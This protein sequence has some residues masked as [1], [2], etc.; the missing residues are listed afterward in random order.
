MPA[1]PDQLDVLV[2]PS[3]WPETRCLVIAEAMARGLPVLASDIGAIKDLV[4]DG[5]TG[6]LFPPN[7]PRALSDRIDYLRTHAELRREMG[8]IRAIMW[9]P[10]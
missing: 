7:D 2:V 1:L 8:E 9:R 5:V 10:A 3:A 6:F 4:E